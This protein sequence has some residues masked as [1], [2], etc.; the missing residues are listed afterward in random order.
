MSASE[1]TLARLLVC[2]SS[3]GYVQKKVPEI[4]QEQVQYRTTKNRKIEKKIGRSSMKW[5]GDFTA[6]GVLAT[7][8]CRLGHWLAHISTYTPSF[9]QQ[10]Y[11]LQDLVCYLTPMLF[12]PFL[13]PS[14]LVQKAYRTHISFLAAFTLLLHSPALSRIPLFLA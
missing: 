8:W 5:C 4:K 2:T 12:L 10:I 7:F 1:K 13:P 3:V 6:R 14:Y 9:S 11:L